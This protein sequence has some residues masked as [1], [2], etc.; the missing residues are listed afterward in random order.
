M[1]ASQLLDRI[2][3]TGLVDSKTL[4]RLRKEVDS[5]SKPLKAKA[6]AKYLVDKGL[7]TQAQIDRLLETASA[8][9]PAGKTQNTDELL[10]LGG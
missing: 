8:G 7:M 5:A 3:Q 6:V 4:T 1:S 2:E 9:A 10:N